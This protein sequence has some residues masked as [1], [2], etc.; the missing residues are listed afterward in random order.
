LK[1]KGELFLF[2]Q[3]ASIHLK[4]RERFFEQTRKLLL[5]ARKKEVNQKLF[6][7]RRTKSR[8]G[9]EGRNCLPSKGKGGAFIF[10]YS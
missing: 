7:A 10:L 2:V 6:L 8:R 9:G 1:K 5:T 4:K 3:S